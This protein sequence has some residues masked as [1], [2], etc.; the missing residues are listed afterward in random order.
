MVRPRIGVMLPI[1]DPFGTGVADIAGAAQHLERVGADSVWVGDHLAFHTPVVEATVA[2]A[3]AAAVTERVRLGFGVLLLALRHP[4]WTAKQITS[5]Q[6]LSNE[7]VDLGIGVGGENPDEWAAAG[8][9]V[10]ERARRT[11]TVLRAL[12][13]LL[14]GKPATV[15]APYH[16]TVPTLSPHAKPPPIWIGGRSEAALRR[17]TLFG[18]GW[19]GMWADAGRIAGARD[20]LRA[21]SDE[22]ARPVPRIG[23]LAFVHIGQNDAGRAETARFIEGQYR[24][25]FGKIER[26]ALIGS[27]SEV[28]AR[29]RE[30]ASAGVEE[31]VLFPAAA[32]HHAQYEALADVLGNE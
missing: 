2:L 5:L 29:L 10:G 6:V 20:R 8:V 25:P 27:A 22:V 16:V 21:L 18:D 7:R 9:P 3:T 4:A 12:P 26:Y 31:F 28:A 1:S 11:D 17:A 13:D 15:D 30:L 14:S 19:L 24:I 32:D 23:L